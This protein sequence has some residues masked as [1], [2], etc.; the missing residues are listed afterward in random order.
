MKSFWSII[1]RYIIKNKKRIVFI[2]LGI[3]LSMALIVSLSTISEALKE[4]LYQKMVDDSGGIYDMDLYTRGFFNFDELRKDNMIEDMTVVI[5]VG[6]YDIPNTENTL[7]IASYD[8]NATDI[9]NFQLIEGKYPEKDNEIALEKWMLDLFPEKYNIGDKIKIPYKITYRGRNTEFFYKDDEAEFIITGLFKNTFRNYYAPSEGKA[10]ITPKYAE[11]LLNKN[12]ITVQEAE[13]RAYITANPMYSAKTV[14]EKLVESDYSQGDFS[15]NYAKLDLKDQYKK[16][17]SI[18]YFIFMVLMI[19]SSIIIYNIFNVSVSE[20]TKEIGMLRAIGCPPWK[21]KM[22]IL[23]EGFLMAIVFIPLG[24]LFGNWI[25]RLI[26]KIST[27]IDNLGSIFSMDI[28]I[29]LI[30]IFI[31][32]IT[33]LIGSYFPAKKAST[34]SPVRAISGSNNLNLDG[35]KIRASLDHKTNISQKISF[36]GHMAYANL[37]RNKKRFLTT[38][39]SLIITITMFM[40]INYIIGSTNPVA[41]FK[42]SFGADFKLNSKMGILDEKI[43]SIPGVKIVS[44]NKQRSTTIEFPREIFTE[45]GI[46][47]LETEAKMGGFLNQLLEQ[48]RYELG[49]E[50]YGYSDKDL[51]KLNEYIIEGEIDI[52]KMKKEKILIVAQHLN[53]NNYT[54]IKVGDILNLQCAKFD[55]SGT[56]LEIGMPDFEVGAIV[57]EEAFK[58]IDKEASVMAIVSEKA[59]ED[60]M[61][62][63]G[64]Q[65]FDLVLDKGADYEKTEALIK[66]KLNDE[67]D[68]EILSFREELAKVKRNNIQIVFAMYSVV[69]VVAIV[70]IIN[71]INIMNMSAIMRKKEFGFMRAMG[72]S[73]KQ[74]KKIIRREGAIYGVVSGGIAVV[75]GSL[76]SIIIAS[77]SKVIF[78]QE[79]TWSFPVLNVISTLAVTIIITIVAAVLPSRVLFKSSIVESIRDIE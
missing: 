6:R 70:S 58:D 50:A 26:I 33:I 75:L 12:K 23:G 56:F 44:K 42:D 31:G 8:D 74:V 49:V 39:L 28:K 48:N 76:I 10:Y 46:K 30:A 4:S 51:E 35:N 16:Y 78:G 55:I 27:G 41:V 18:M 21:I 54:N 32:V 77:K 45:E 13:S 73:E 2:A 25:T 37:L 53:E 34:I 3:M 29:L 67:R 24:I 61:N 40:V 66:E 20:R 7:E 59:M 22:M 9:L 72:L 11:Q 69:I 38:S 5:P 63:Y 64:Y 19:I 14:V 43:S 17:D 65:H 36:E 15:L 47:H 68:L 79:I 60:Y 1:P 62:V 71:L 52:E 57:S